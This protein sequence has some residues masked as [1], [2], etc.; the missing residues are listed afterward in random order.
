MIPEEPAGQ[1]QRKF[2]IGFNRA[3]RIIDQLNKAGVVGPA[4]G[5]KPRQVLMT[6]EQFEVYLGHGDSTGEAASEDEF[7]LAQEFADQEEAG[8]AE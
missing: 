4:V 6:M 5:T 1:L 2:S 3:G 8:N 7:A